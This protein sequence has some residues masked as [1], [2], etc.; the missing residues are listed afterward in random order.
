MYLIFL[1]NLTDFD[2]INKII[3]SFNYLKIYIGFLC[4]CLFV[5]HERMSR[6]QMEVSDTL[7]LVLEVCEPSCGFC[8]FRCL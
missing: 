8:E 4:V 3:L 5:L 2:K 6:H 7:E 1:L